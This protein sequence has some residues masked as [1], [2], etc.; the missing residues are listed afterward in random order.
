MK[1]RNRTLPE[2]FLKWAGGKRQ[3][4]PE[5]RRRVRMAGEFSRYHEPFVG[6]GA[7]F[8]DLYRDGA[9]GTEQAMLV[10][11]NSRLIETYLG[12]RD[13]VERVIELLAAHHAQHSK[14]HYYAVRAEAPKALPERA[15]RIIYLNRTCFNGLYRENRQGR[16]NVPYGDYKRPRICDAENLR[17]VSA[18]LKAAQLECRDFATVVDWAQPGD[19]VYFDPPYHPVSKTSSFTAY[20][21]GGFGEAEQRKLAEVFAALTAKGVRALLS[22]SWTP[23]IHELYAPWRIEEVQATRNVNSKAEGRGKI[24]E[25]LVRNFNNRGKLLGS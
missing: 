11:N 13:H 8:F 16:F 18:A 21:Q 25:A 15:A 2:P 12:V 3:L 20:H 14:D 24:T 5:L 22:N 19:F 4:L 7:L 23:L 9:L 1:T 10:D 17:A 6:G